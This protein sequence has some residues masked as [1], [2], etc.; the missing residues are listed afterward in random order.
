MHLSTL[1]H[2]ACL[3]SGRQ[4]TAICIPLFRRPQPRNWERLGFLHQRHLVFRGCRL[5]NAAGRPQKPS[6]SGGSITAQRWLQSGVQISAAESTRTAPLEAQL[7]VRL[8]HLRCPTSLPL[9]MQAL[10]PMGLKCH[11]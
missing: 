5:W 4:T 10:A 1:T 8:P 11:L 6:L 3:A 2:T 7:A 9:T